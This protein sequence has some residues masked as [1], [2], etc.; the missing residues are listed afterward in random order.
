M[1]L[2]GD[3]I[4]KKIKL[5]QRSFAAN[6]VEIKDYETD[7]D[8]K[9]AAYQ[10]RERVWEYRARKDRRSNTSFINEHLEL[11]YIY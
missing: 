4:L 8:T 2:I 7:E 1:T 5:I 3:S 10:I 6:G 11:G 9:D